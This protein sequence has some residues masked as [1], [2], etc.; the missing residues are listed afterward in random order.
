MLVE[1]FTGMM[2][3]PCV[4]ADMALAA[5]AKSLPASDAIVLRFHQHIPMADGL[6]NQDSEERGAFYEISSAP[7]ILVDGIMMD[8]RWYA[9]PIQ[10]AP[11]G[12][13]V[14]R[15]VIDPRLAEKSEITLQLSAA[16]SDGQLAI[17]VEADGIPED[18]LPACRLRMAIVENVVHTYGPL[19]TNGIR[20]HENVVR[21]MPGSAKGIPPKNGELKYSLK[22]PI[23][24]IQK[25]VVD[26]ISRF[27]AGRRGEFP[28]EMKPPIRG[29]L[30]LVAWV[31]NGN[32]DPTTHAKMVLQ[33][34]LVPITGFDPATEADPKPA[35]KASVEAPA[36]AGI[37]DSSESTPP[38]PA[39][40]E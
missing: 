21:E 27:E 2:C 8:P 25:N 17:S 18:L 28:P 7:L 5:L 38:P 39:L 30:S 22:V 29:P 1:F 15:K 6:V 19:T 16:V 23:A 12:Y 34:A 9:G 20:E 36:S 4:A 31:Q 37:G 11:T 3:P 13:G 10:I 14:L 33:S 24:D 35:P 26:H 32:P 40:P